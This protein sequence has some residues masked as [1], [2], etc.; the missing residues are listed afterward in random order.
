MTPLTAT[1]WATTAENI[2]RKWQISREDQD[3]FAVG[4]QNKAE[5]AQ[6]AG[7]FKDEIVPVTI[8]SRK[9]DIV[10]EADEISARRRNLRGDGEAEAGFFQGRDR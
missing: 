1:T 9:G 7:R 2:A 8:S 6:K 10:V 4:S 5:A 3:R